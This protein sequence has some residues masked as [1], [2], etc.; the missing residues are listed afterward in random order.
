VINCKDLSSDTIYHTHSPVSHIIP[1]STD[2][3]IAIGF[4]R[5][6]YKYGKENGT[7]DLNSCLTKSNEDSVK[8]LKEEINSNMRDRLKMFSGSAKKTSIA[9]TTDQNKNT[10]ASNIHSANLVADYIVTCDLTG[11]LKYWQ[12]K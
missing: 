5:H 4:D 6:I 10:H 8:E 3:F 7:W 9:I 2:C 11:F 12:I 1:I